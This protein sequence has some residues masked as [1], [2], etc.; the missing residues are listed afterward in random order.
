MRSFEDG[1]DKVLPVAL[2]KVYSRATLIYRRCAYRS[3]E[4]FSTSVTG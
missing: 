2:Q 3:I 4:M 1:L